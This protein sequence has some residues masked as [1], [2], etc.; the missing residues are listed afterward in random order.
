MNEWYSDSDRDSEVKIVGKPVEWT[1]EPKMQR[2]KPTKA[3][4]IV[5]RD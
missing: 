2:S 3:G 5:G 1:R 4:M